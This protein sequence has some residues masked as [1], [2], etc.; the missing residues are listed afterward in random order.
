M[1]LSEWVKRENRKK[2]SRKEKEDERE[3]GN[4]LQIPANK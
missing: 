1:Q 4:T 3:K 2:Q